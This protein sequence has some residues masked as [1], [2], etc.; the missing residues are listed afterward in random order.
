MSSTAAIQ[1]LTTAYETEITTISDVIS[2]A[3]ATL[4][5]TELTDAWSAQAKL[6]AKEITQYSISGRSFSY[7]TAD[8]MNGTIK[9]LQFELERLLYGDYHLVNASIGEALNIGSGRNG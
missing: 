8:E 1:A 5:L 6:N 4:L 3:K 2:N 9:E 7:K